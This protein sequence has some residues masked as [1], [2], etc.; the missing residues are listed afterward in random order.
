MSAYAVPVLPRGQRGVTVS[1]CSL[2][3]RNPHPRLVAGPGTALMSAYKIATEVLGEYLHCKY[4]AYL[5]LTG[6]VSE[7]S[8]YEHW[9]QRNEEQYGAA[10]R[11]ILVR[12]NSHLLA[13]QS[14]TSEHLIQN[15]A[16]IVDSHIQREH[17]TY[18]CDA[19]QRVPGASQLGS[20][21]Y[22][23]VLFSNNK[24]SRENQKLRLCCN[25]LILEQLQQLYPRTGM[26]VSGAAYKSRTVDLI[27]QRHKA[28]KVIND[29]TAYLKREDKPRLGSQ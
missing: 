1:S 25:G 16:F 23:P 9:L 3:T 27:T 21:H 4:K 15:P 8:E 28:Q 2:L 13:V 24:S 19:L 14:L 10:A 7:R 29:L 26:L 5:I 18:Y 11:S 12:D 6:V 20:F 22:A 17:F